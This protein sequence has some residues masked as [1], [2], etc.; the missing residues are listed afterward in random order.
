VFFSFHYA[1]DIQRVNVVRNHALTKGGVE[2]SGYWDHSLW[3]E[4]KAKG[5][6]SLKRLIMEGMSNTSVTVILN[7][8]ETGIRRWVRYE[9]AKSV[10]RGNGLLVVNIS[11]IKDLSQKT[12]SQGGN[13]FTGLRYSMSPDGKTLAL[14]QYT[15]EGWRDYMQFADPGRYKIKPGQSGVVSEY[16]KNRDWISGDGYSNFA[17]WVELAAKSV[18]R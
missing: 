14:Q 2:S 5:D 9:M 17:D 6:E 11:S 4:T 10:E 13:P 18:G 15:V 8:S 12:S 3:E 1:N 7:G 16:S